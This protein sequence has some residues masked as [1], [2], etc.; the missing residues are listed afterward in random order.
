MKVGCLLFF[1]QIAVVIG[2]YNKIKKRKFLKTRD[3]G[4]PLRLNKNDH[5]LG[6]KK[7]RGG[8]GLGCP[9]QFSAWYGVYGFLAR[10]IRFNL[11]R[12]I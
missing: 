3:R 9:K 2:E 7:R 8:R 5:E 11:E 4:K 12:N 10:K 1:L 6:E